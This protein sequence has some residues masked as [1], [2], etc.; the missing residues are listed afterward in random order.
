MFKCVFIERDFMEKFLFYNGFHMCKAD[1]FNNNNQQVSDTAGPQLPTNT[2]SVMQHAFSSDRILCTTQLLLT[3]NFIIYR[4][5][6]QHLHSNG[7][8]LKFACV[9]CVEIFTSLVT[10]LVK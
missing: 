2:V 7:F 8:E 3:S 5:I 6:K 1:S 9:V 10:S 4:P